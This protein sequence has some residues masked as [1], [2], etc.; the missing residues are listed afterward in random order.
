MRNTM[1]TNYNGKQQHENKHA[2][3]IKSAQRAKRAYYDVQRDSH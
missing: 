2:I 1:D 3:R